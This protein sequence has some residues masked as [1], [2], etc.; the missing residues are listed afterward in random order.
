MSLEKWLISAFEGLRDAVFLLDADGVLLNVNSAT[1]VLLGYAPDELQGQPIGRILPEWD[2]EQYQK[3]VLGGE[4]LTQQ[5][6]SLQC[7]NGTSVIVDVQWRLLRQGETSVVQLIAQVCENVKQMS[8]L[9]GTGRA[10]IQTLIEN[11]P[12]QVF[13][14]DTQHRV[15][16]CNQ[17]TSSI[18]NITPEQMR[19][20]TDH[21]CFPKEKAD[22][23]AMLEDRVLAGNP[24]VNVEENYTRANGKNVWNLSTKVPLYDEHGN[25]FGLVGVNREITALKQL[26]IE[27]REARDVAEQASVAKSAFLANMS[28]EI[29]T[30]LNAVIGMTSLLADTPLSSDQRDFVET[31]ET[32][33]EALLTLINDILDLSKIEAG[34]LQLEEVPFNLANCVEN[35]LDIVAP[36]AAQKGL[37]LAYSTVGDVPQMFFGD[38]PRLRQV[39]LN[40]LSNSIKFTE[41]GEVVV[42]ISGS[43]LEKEKHRIKFS[44]IDTGI[45]MS[46]EQL[47]K[48]FNPFEQA[49]ASTTRRFGGTGL[50]LSICKRLIEMMGGDIDVKSKLNC[51]SEFQF[52]IVLK[53]A[54]SD[55]KAHHKL[56]LK[57][58]K[59]RR[60]LIVDDNHT[61]LQILEHQLK[62]WAMVPLVFSSGAD[63]LLHLGRLGEVHLAVL[64]MMMPDMDGVMLAE[65]LRKRIEFGARPIL[66]LSSFSR[67]VARDT[68][69]VND[70]L[71]KPVKPALLMESLANLIE[72]HVV[73]QLIHPA[74][75]VVNHT[76]GITYPLEILLAEDNLVNQKVALKLLERL[77]YKADLAKN[78]KVAVDAVA[79]KQYDLVLMDIQMPVMDGIEATL[80]IKKQYPSEICPKIVAMTAHAL[81]ESRD[82]GMDC[83]MFDYLAKPV[84]LEELIQILRK[85][86]HKKHG[87][88][89]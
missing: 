62:S 80:A 77:G 44:V 30:P 79:K 33:G 88:A 40:L 21:D 42:R 20:R 24:I 2:S 5:E 54:A 27:L 87:L 58:L 17:A 4:E 72:G 48:I 63:A 73:D 16:L 65:A 82:E 10:V 26:E 66:I 32:S 36:K 34:R 3:V 37:E 1:G 51:G 7:R 14:K 64:D 55:E 57:A 74:K 84:R 15:V 85:V 28:H 68:T 9:T 59:G 61:N 81:Q 60:V 23:F 50:G 45:G 18:Y 78:G 12:D 35:A 71:C 41:R 19:G 69:A 43:P 6:V 47:K 25:V 75:D 46:P 86:Y 38:A 83:G 89:D 22:V 52:H 67:Q 11:I 8:I 76:L 70:W 29:R 49:D 31:I 53:R 56:N 13:I 39:L